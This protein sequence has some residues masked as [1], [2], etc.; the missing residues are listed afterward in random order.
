[1]DRL[2]RITVASGF[3]NVIDAFHNLQGRETPARFF[4]DNRKSKVGITVTDELLQLKESSQFPSLLPE[5]ESRWRLVETAWQLRLSRSTLLVSVDLETNLIFAATSSL[6][7][8]TITTCRDA[9]NGY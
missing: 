2:R 5:A 9:L 8:P 1:L 4:A 7:R 6:R 3:Q